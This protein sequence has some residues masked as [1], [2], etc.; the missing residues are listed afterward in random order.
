MWQVLKEMKDS[1][2]RISDPKKL[3]ADAIDTMTFFP[4]LRPASDQIQGCTF[5]VPP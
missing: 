4:F 1:G 3:Q 5:L 2:V